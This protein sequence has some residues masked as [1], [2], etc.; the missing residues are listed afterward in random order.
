M[1]FL[2]LAGDLQSTVLRLRGRHSNRFPTRAQRKGNGSGS[3]TNHHRL[4]QRQ[5]I[6]AIA[7]TRRWTT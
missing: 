7:G 4:G 3:V 6:G 1:R 5:S 2:P